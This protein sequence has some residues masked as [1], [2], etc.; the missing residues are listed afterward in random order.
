LFDKFPEGGERHPPSGV[1]PDRDARSGGRVFVGLTDE[2]RIFAHLK[3]HR[4]E[5]SEKGGER[6]A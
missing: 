3:P 5:H 4:V 6:E 1:E 2:T